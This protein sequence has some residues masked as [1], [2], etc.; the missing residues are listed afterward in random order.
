MPIKQ[1]LVLGKFVCRWHLK[2][3]MLLPIWTNPAIEELNGLD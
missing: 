3:S 2:E 1:K